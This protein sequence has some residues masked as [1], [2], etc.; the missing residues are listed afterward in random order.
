ML[1]L[2]LRLPAGV[3]SSVTSPL[4]SVAATTGSSLVPVMSTLTVRETL[5][6]WP[7]RTS[8][9]KVSILCWP[10]ARYSTSDA[11]TL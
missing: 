3:T 10:A 1:P 4:T 7:S 6:P 8:K 11:A 9:V 5:P 2:S